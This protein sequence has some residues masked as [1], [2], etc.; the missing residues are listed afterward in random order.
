MLEFLVEIGSLLLIGA[1]GCLF[2]G[3]FTVKTVI[4][5]SV[6]TVA[7]WLMSFVV[8]D[9]T[10]LEVLNELVPHLKGML[11]VYP[12][13][14]GLA[15]VDATDYGNV[16]YSIVGGA[17][18]IITGIILLPFY[19]TGLFFGFTLWPELFVFGLIFR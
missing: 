13:A 14:L 7:V 8:A 12:R 3:F 19:I 17:T 6:A 15:W 9:F 1:I 2:I 5:G 10:G 18:V 4:W 16:L 11:T